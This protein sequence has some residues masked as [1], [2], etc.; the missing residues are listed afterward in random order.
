MLLLGIVGIEEPTKRC[1]WDR[2]GQVYL[3]GVLHV[4]MPLGPWG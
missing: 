1:H 2:A 4:Q 3:D